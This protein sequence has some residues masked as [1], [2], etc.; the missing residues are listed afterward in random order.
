MAINPVLSRRVREMFTNL[1]HV[2]EKKM[3]GG[4]AFMI[5]NEMCVTVQD[6]HI[7]CRIDPLIHEDVV[8]LPGVTTVKMKGRDYIGWVYVEESIIPGKKQLHHWIKLALEYNAQ[9]K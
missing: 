1:P 8:S 3:F 7:M 6:D 2:E 9:V 5:N 4:I